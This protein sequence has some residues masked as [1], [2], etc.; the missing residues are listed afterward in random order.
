MYFYFIENHFDSKIYQTSIH[1]FYYLA[2]HLCYNLHTIII[3][4]VYL[5]QSLAGGRSDSFYWYTI[6]YIC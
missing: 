1:I 6:G 5:K 2:L 4:R 3:C